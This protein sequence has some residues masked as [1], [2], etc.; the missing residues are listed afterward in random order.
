MTARMTETQDTA[1]P[2]QEVEKAQTLRRR[3]CVCPNDYTALIT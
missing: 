2:T 3:T 1:S